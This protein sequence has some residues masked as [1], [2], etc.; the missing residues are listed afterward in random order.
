MWVSSQETKL[1]ELHGQ[2]Y[3]SLA[4]TLTSKHIQCIKSDFLN[5]LLTFNVHSAKCR[6]LNYLL[7]GVLTNLYALC[8]NTQNGMFFHPTEYP[9]CFFF[10]PISSHRGTVLTPIS[11]DSFSASS[12]T[13]YGWNHR[14]H[15]T[16]S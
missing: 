15:I 13:L 10:D 16:F 4:E 6:V 9:R 8:I 2:N 7:D 5:F 14:A 3:D 1:L 11:K 12:R